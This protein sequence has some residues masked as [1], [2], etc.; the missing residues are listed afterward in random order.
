MFSSISQAEIYDVKGSQNAPTNASDSA[1]PAEA[2]KKHVLVLYG[3]ETGTA[4]GYAYDTAA[5]L[6]CFTTH[7]RNCC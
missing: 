6:R 4:E 1:A 7:V 5:R 3:S 2:S